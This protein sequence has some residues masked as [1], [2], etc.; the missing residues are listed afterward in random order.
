MTLTQTDSLKTDGRRERLVETTLDLLAFDTQNPPG[1]TRQT[2][3]WLE[4][5]VTDLGIDFQRIGAER[6]KPNVVATI[7]GEREWTLLYEGHLDTVPYDRDCWSNDPLG[8]RVDDL[9]CDRWRRRQEAPGGG[10]SRSGVCRRKRHRPRRRRARLDRRARTD[11]RVVSPTPGPS[12]RVDRVPALA[13][14]SRG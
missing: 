6:D 8:E 9:L 13:V 4:R 1:E 2:F 14:S 3:D 7:L 12:R 5:H 11:R 10:R